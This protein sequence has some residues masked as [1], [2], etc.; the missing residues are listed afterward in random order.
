MLKKRID[1]LFR[2][3]RVK[4]LSPYRSPEETEACCLHNS[5]K[6]TVS[7]RCTKLKWHF[8]IACRFRKYA[9]C[10]IFR[11]VTVFDINIAKQK[12]EMSNCIFDLQSAYRSIGKTGEPYGR[13][14]DAL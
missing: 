12:T 13:K 14:F 4:N 8:S 5:H 6:S 1:F 9:G 10:T 7:L 2:I 11:K 3:T